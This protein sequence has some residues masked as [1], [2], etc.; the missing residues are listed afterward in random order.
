MNLYHYCSLDKC[1]NILKSKTIRLSDISKS[2]DAS[3]LELMFPILHRAI[4]KKYLAN[5]FS[6]KWNKCTN[7]E[8][9]YSL[10]DTSEFYWK[11]QLEQGNFTN[12]V[13]CFS[14]VKDCLSQW[15][16]Y[17]DDGRGCCIGFSKDTL[18]Q[19]C[20][21]TKGVLLFKKV[22][23]IT[24]EEIDEMV[25]NI[26][27][28]ILK[29]LRTLREWIIENMTH[30]DNSPDTDGLLGYNFDGMLGHAFTN[31]LCFKFRHF[32]EE[33]EWRLFLADKAYKESNWVLD[34]N[35]EIQGPN[36]FNETLDFLNNRIDFWW[37]AN[38]LISFCPLSFEEFPI[39]PITELLLGPKSM[40]RNSDMKLFLK[41][42]GYPEISIQS[43]SIPYR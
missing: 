18:Q 40:I 1:F 41:K 31:S 11:K 19:F 4:L 16:G 9:M 5:P 20:D 15:R 34:K 6:F 8:A 22:K 7:A 29:T 35:E 10:I 36:M 24:Q 27:D 3:E 32:S 17:A 14:E 37:T 2:N 23:Y 26:A 12:F 38:D 21:T 30:D 39:M 42:Y 28:M 43:S 13:L 25:V 33:N